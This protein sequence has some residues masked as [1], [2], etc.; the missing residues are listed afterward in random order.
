MNLSTDQ[1]WE[2]FELTFVKRDEN[3]TLTDET[4]IHIYDNNPDLFLSVKGKSKHNIEVAINLIS[5]TLKLESI[6]IADEE[7]NS[8]HFAL[9]SY[10]DRET[11]RTAMKSV[12]PK[13][14]GLGMK[15]RELVDTWV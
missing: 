6:D 8:Q 12:I 3:E 5:E 13:M 1:T 14:E 9:P 11:M 15:L 2:I 7:E 4:T 10:P